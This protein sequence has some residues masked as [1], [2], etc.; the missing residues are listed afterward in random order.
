MRIIE[1]NASLALGGLT[2]ALLLTTGCFP[3]D[4]GD[5][6]SGGGNVQMG[7]LCAASSDCGG[8]GTCLKGVCSGYR[9]ESDDD[10]RA[11]QVCGSVLGARSC[12]VQC[13]TDADCGGRQRCTEVPEGVEAY[14]AVSEL[15]L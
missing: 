10:C 5:D 12:V 9:C 14:A 4:P 11:E 13:T 8:E 15:C 2:L 7:G 1:R 3:V 6:H